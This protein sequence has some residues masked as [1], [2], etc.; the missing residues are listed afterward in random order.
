GT[1]LIEAFK[2]WRSWADGVACCDYAFRVAV[3]EFIAGKTDAEMDTLVKEHG[4]NSFKCFMA[5]KDV[6]MLRDED[7]LKVFQKCRDLGAL[8]L[9]HAENGD[10]ID[11]NVKKLKSLGITGPEGH[12]HSRPEEVEC[13]ATN[14]AI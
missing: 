9:V 14:R 4:V 10:I 12:L 11:Y 13:E 7:L 6:L 1:S 8:P 5:Y 3:P 2:K